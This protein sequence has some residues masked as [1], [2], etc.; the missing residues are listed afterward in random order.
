MTVVELGEIGAELPA[1]HDPDK[2]LDHILRERDARRG[3]SG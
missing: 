2:L 3:R 1:E